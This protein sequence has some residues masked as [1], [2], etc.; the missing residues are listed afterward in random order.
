MGEIPVVTVDSPLLILIPLRLGLD[1]I[2]IEMYAEDLKSTLAYPQSLG[3][4]GGRPRFAY[5]FF[6]YSESSGELLALDPHTVKDF[7]GDAGPDTQSHICESPLLVPS[8]DRLDPSMA[9]GF[10]TKNQ[11]E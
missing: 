11:I 6:G 8:V 10:L 2:N 7:T 3:I 1:E 4:I 9:L 5:Y